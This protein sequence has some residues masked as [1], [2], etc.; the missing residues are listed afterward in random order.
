MKPYNFN[1][2]KEHTLPANMFCVK[3][4]HKVISENE[5]K[6]HLL[7]IVQNNNYIRPTVKQLNKI[8]KRK[9]VNYWI[10]FPDVQEPQTWIIF[11]YH[12]SLIRKFGNSFKCSKF[13]TL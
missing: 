8:I 3:R 4:N 1:L 6:N 10:D 13:H 7:Q 11:K 12:S 5:N 2:P 9:F